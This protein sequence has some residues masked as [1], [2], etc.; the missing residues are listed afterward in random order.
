VS[1]NDDEEHCFLKYFGFSTSHVLWYVV[2]N[3][4]RTGGIFFFRVVA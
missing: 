1:K 3:K 4:V 2:P